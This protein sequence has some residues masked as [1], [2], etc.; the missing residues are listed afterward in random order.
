MKQQG[1]TRVVKN[2]EASRAFYE[3]VL[4]LKPGPAYEPTRWQMYEMENGAFFAIGEA[5]G[6][7][8]EIGF[9]TRNV[10]GLWERVKDRVEVVEPLSHTPWGTYRFVIRDPDGHL[11][12]FAQD[13]TYPVP[14]KE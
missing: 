1:V 3:R 7:T 4:G 12:A 11:V 10:E 14:G 5:P 8:D 2:L 13:P 9:T 6:S